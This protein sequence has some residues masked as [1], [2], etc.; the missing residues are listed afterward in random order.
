MKWRHFKLGYRRQMTFQA[1]HAKCGLKWRHLG[2][3]TSQI[4]PVEQAN[5]KDEQ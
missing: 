5:D 3:R 1:W 4:I 2:E